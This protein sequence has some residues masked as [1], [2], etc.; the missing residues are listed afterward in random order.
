MSRQANLEHGF[1]LVEV[2]IV[3]VLIAL[4]ASIIFGSL[5]GI[6]ESRDIFERRAKV[7]NQSRLLLSQLH[8]ELSSITTTPI[9]LK[10]DSAS[11]SSQGSTLY[12][13][14]RS[15]IF[16]EHQSSGEF[17]QDTLIFTSQ[18]SG[19]AGGGKET[20]RSDIQVSYHLERNDDFSG[21]STRHVSVYRLIRTEQPAGVTDEKV[22]EQGSLE[23]AVASNIAHFRVRFLEDSNE[24]KWAPDWSHGKTASPLAIEI[25]LGVVNEVGKVTVFR[26][27]QF[28]KERNLRQS[29]GRTF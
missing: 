23:L 18:G 5:R 16:G 24:P 21:E 11:Q 2:I 25:A 28:L 29:F 19:R 20:N 9:V 12:R 6:V 8:R 14:N 17:S 4:L 22:I 1:T 26:T 7:S 27:S 10:S 13:K 15:A 3:T